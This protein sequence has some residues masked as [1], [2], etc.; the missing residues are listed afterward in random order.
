MAEIY[1][2]RTIQAKPEKD[3]AA[4]PENRTSVGIRVSIVGIL[5]NI[6]LFAVKLAAGYL[7]QATSVV[8]DAVNNLSDAASSVV[9]LIGM[10]M[11]GKP[12]DREH[13]FGH[14]RMEYVA[15]L[16]VAFLIMAIG[17]SFLRE[18]VDHILHPVVMGQSV[19]MLA[20]LCATVLVKLFLFALFR[21]AGRK[22]DSGIFRASSMDSLFDAVITS[23]TIFSVGVYRV[24][25]VNVD[26][27][28]GLLVSLIIIWSGIGVIRDT[29]NP[30]LG[31]QMDEEMC[32]QIRTIV[33][34]QPDVVGMHDLIVHNYGADRNFATIHVELPRTMNVEEAHQIADA[35]EE[36][37]RE[38]LGVFLVAHVDPAETEDENVLR[39]KE[40]VQR[41]LS[42]LD[43]ELSIHDFSMTEDEN[44]KILRF[45]LQVPYTYTTETELR[46]TRQLMDLL[47][48]IEPGCQCLIRVDRGIT[49]EVLHF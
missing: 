10:N 37:V 26:G 29:L 44:E 11:S 21:S 38:E 6:L 2:E 5:C 45:D 22:I 27:F 32:E 30:L 20:V 19:P 42:I 34:S 43:P 49:E 1:S 28:A 17:L 46:V 9:S 31:Q 3:T 8:A 40:Q 14:G 13:P 24:S 15:A 48:E 33:G 47:R 16:T 23:V 4:V 41:L 35:A 25:G 39:Q 36:K 12:A 18:S 7:L